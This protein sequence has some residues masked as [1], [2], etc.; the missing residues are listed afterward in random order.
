MKRLSNLIARFKGDDK[1]LERVL[2]AESISTDENQE[3]IHK[4][5]ELRGALELL[6][7]AGM[8]PNV[9]GSFMYPAYTDEYPVPNDVDIQS[10]L[11]PVL[12]NAME[13]QINKRTGKPIDL[14]ALG[15]T[16]ADCDF[17]D[18]D[19]IVLPPMLS[20]DNPIIVRSDTAADRPLANAFARLLENPDNFKNM[21]A[22]YCLSL[23]KDIDMAKVLHQI[24]TNSGNP[25]LLMMTGFYVE[26]MYKILESDKLQSLWADGKKNTIATSTATPEKVATQIKHITRDLGLDKWL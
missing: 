10:I 9:F 13:Y 21:Y 5:Y 15:F 16:I 22:C 3:T 19:P 14:D 11:S 1:A 6:V 20:M 7:E 25:H 17:A 23:A 24:L 18:A 8:S 12:R 2:R 26:H 4:Y